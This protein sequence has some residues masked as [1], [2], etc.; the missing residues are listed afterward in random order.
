MISSNCPICSKKKIACGP[1][2]KH[3]EKIQIVRE[4]CEAC[5]PHEAAD[6]D[7]KNVANITISHKKLKEGA[8][9]IARNCKYD[10]NQRAL[11]SMI[12]KVFDRKTGSG[13]IVN[14]HL[15]EKLHKTAI[16]KMKRRKRQ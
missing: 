4:T 5:F 9:K 15:A 1:F 13:V 12:Y 8:Y 6:S 11:V 14:E 3:R 7:S 10:E 16:K 2:T